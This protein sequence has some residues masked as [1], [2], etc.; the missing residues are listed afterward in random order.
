[1]NNDQLIDRARLL[2]EQQRHEQAEDLLRQALVQD[3]DSGMIHSLLAVS[4]KRDR[5]K[6][7]AA[8]L[9]AERG[10][11]LAPDDPFSHYA[12]AAVQASRNQDKQ[13]L[14]SIGQAIALAPLDAGLHGFQS[15]LF[16][17]LRRWREAL[18]AA[19]VGL[20]LD[21][22]DSTC[23]SARVFSLERL[24]RVTDALGEAE[25][26]VRNEPD[27]SDAHAARGWAMLQAGKYRDA[28]VSF[29]EALRLEPSSEFA[30]HGMITALNSSNPIFRFFDG[31]MTRI[32]RM[33]GG[34]QWALV[35]GLF[36]GTRVLNSLAVEHPWLRPYVL[37]ITLAYLLFVM[38]SWI[39]QPLF[40]TLLR[41]H[42]FGRYLLSRKEVWASQL[43]ATAILM[44]TVV[45]AIAMA[46]RGGQFV[47]GALPFLFGVFLTIPIS[48]AFRTSVRWATTAA[49][50]AAGA[51]S[52]LFIAI[53][54]GLLADRVHQ[55]WL[56]SYQLGILL[57]CFAG[58]ALI[59]QQ[60]QH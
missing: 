32:S 15:Q 17:K 52:L 9:A 27:S 5:D 11:H 2:L 42:P 60:P 3:P 33:S 19:E 13:A 10:V 47:D 36:F 25:R 28:Q 49:I 24:G 38:M 31:I 6:L 46:M 51:F 22:D 50:T 53:C 56:A 45:G 54:I 29:R 7:A 8:S 21:P 40:N 18:E 37:P 57:Y 14:A 41:F 39:M 4:L 26:A 16:I 48:V 44:G 34:M 58:Q 30:R 43:I 55:S 12:M 35:L 59:A 23:A 20:S 1:M